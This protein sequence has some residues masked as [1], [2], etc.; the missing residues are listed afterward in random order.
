MIITISKYISSVVHLISFLSLIFDPSPPQATQ[1]FLYLFYIFST[2]SLL[3]ATSP[4]GNNESISYIVHLI[5]MLSLIHN[6]HIS[7]LRKTVSTS[8]L[9]CFP[10]RSHI[11]SDLELK[12][13]TDGSSNLFYPVFTSFPRLAATENYRR[14]S[15]SKSTILSSLSRSVLKYLSFMVHLISIFCLHLIPTPRNHKKL[16]A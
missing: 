16:S 15:P 4:F 6:F 14:N 7:Y 2:A 11:T 13:C 10:S 3:A 8:L 12:Y 1:H 5:S 9:N